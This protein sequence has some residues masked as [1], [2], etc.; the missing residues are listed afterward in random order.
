MATSIGLHEAAPQQLPCIPYELRIGVT[1]HREF[2]DP[3]AIRR[4][5][6]EL[7]ELLV[8]VLMQDG[9]GDSG[10]G[11]SGWKSVIERLDS[12]LTSFLSVG[13]RFV[14]PAVNGVFRVLRMPQRWNWPVV[15]AV[16]RPTPVSLTPLKLTAVSCLAEGADQMLAEELHRLLTDGPAPGVVP[17][18]GRNRYIEAILPF[19]PDEYERDFATADGVASFRRLLELDRGRLFP[20][21]G[22][23]VVPSE[24]SVAGEN[25]RHR[26][27]RAFAT[28]GRQVVE[29]CEIL[30][31]VWN[32]ERVELAGGTGETARHAL[33]CGRVVIWLNPRQLQ[34]GWRVLRPRPVESP[35]AGSTS[36]SGIDV[37]ANLVAVPLPQTARELSPSFHQLAAYNR[38][39]SVSVDE[40]SRSLSIESAEFRTSASGRLPDS[41]I[42]VITGR[43]LPHLVKADLLSRRYRELRDA[44]ARLWPILAATAVAL[45]ALQILFLPNQYWLGWIELLLLLTCAA[46]YRVSLREAWHDKWRNDRRLAEA[47]R[48]VLYTSLAGDAHLSSRSLCATEYDEGGAGANPLPFYDPRQTWF[49]GAVKRIVRHERRAMAADIDPE[50]DLPGVAEFLAEEWLRGQA[51]Y[52]R[53]AAARHHRQA[54]RYTHWRVLLVGLIILTSVVHALGIGHEHH[55]TGVS[56]FARIDLWIAWAT[57][58]LPAWAAA[59]HALSTSEDFERLGARSHRM[60]PLLNALADRMQRAGTRSELSAALR[61]AESLLDLESHEW[62]ESLSERKP[63]FSG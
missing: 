58:A 27:A 53:S 47:L 10:G 43:I 21:S 34:Q 8:E 11:S 44:A 62:A 38:D 9:R 50:R 17:A 56:P 61:E 19:A 18:S 36:P 35:A 1:G 45:M 59:L 20:L 23:V 42:T 54:R 57:V 22:P 13:T 16:A 25:E 55:A 26:R 15:P 29:T 46:F 52:H 14:C 12:T 4:A 63:E 28:A 5:I 32:P 33:E 40:L 24:S 49:I 41:V 3:A 30:I 37:P 31:A 51:R 39:S 7:L 2:D 60:A 6:R 48:S